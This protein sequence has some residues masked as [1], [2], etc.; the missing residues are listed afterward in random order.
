M[1]RSN[2][3]LSVTIALAA[4][5]TTD[6]MDITLQ[7]V[8]PNGAVRAGVVE[9]EMWMSENASGIGLTADS[10]SGTLTASTG[11][12]LT[13]HTAKKH[14]S[15]VTDANG[16]AVLT[17]V[18]SANPADQYVVVRRPGRADLVVSAASGTSWEGA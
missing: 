7:V 1:A 5:A 8:G 3:T 15:L 18:D 13:A 6:G 9:L 16:R 14:V 12:I 2:P 17:L 10:Y 4:S 11:S